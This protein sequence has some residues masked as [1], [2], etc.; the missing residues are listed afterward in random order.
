MKFNISELH[1]I[2]RN[3]EARIEWIKDN[4]QDFSEEEGELK[5]L[6]SVFQKIKSI[7]LEL[8]EKAGDLCKVKQT[9]Y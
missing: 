3:I 2:K 1:F 6:E 9:Q 5:S 4:P 7:N 8:N